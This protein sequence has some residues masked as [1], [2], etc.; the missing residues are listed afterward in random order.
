[1]RVIKTFNEPIAFRSK[2]R[3]G[4]QTRKQLIIEALYFDL[5]GLKLSKFYG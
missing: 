2:Y 5:E 4:K 3:G 1:M